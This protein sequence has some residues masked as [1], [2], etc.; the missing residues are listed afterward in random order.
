M[1]RVK[2]FAAHPTHRHTSD[3][4]RDEFAERLLD[5]GFAADPSIAPWL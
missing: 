1:R 3:A 5:R 2:R 4:R